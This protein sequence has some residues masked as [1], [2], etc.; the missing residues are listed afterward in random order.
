VGIRII[1]N[2]FVFADLFVV[3]GDGI[4]WLGFVIFPSHGNDPFM[5]YPA[6]CDASA[7]RTTDNDHGQ[8]LFGTM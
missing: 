6:R 7:Q 1:G 4:F 8:F 2:E 5:I 3:A